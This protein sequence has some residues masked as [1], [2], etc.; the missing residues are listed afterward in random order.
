MG[1]VH[2]TGALWWQSATNTA[3]A[4][5]LRLTD[6]EQAVL[7]ALAAEERVSGHEVIRRASM[8][9]ASR[10]GHAARGDAALG[11]A[12]EDWSGLLERL[13]TV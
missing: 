2:L 8:E 13:R 3:M 10:R 1:A 5:T 6:E 9:R 11:E 12:M 7:N 4:M